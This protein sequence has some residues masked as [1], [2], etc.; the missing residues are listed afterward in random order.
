MSLGFWPV[1]LQGSLSRPQ[2]SRSARA[3]PRRASKTVVGRRLK[4]AGMRWSVP[5]AKAVLWIR[6]ANLSGWFDHWADRLGL[7]A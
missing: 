6:C 2:V 3:G 5:G 4:C 7:A 1:P